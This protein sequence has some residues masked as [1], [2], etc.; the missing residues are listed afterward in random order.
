MNGGIR[1]RDR[2]VCFLRSLIGTSAMSGTAG[3]TKP[4]CKGSWKKGIDVTGYRISWQCTVCGVH[5][6]DYMIPEHFGRFPDALIG[7]DVSNAG[8]ERSLY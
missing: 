5:F 2:L 7:K 6:N 8:V 3:H 4:F 1:V